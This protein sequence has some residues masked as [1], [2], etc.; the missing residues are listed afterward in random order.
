M[1]PL[2]KIKALILPP[3]LP[4]R[5]P[6]QHVPVP[7]PDPYLERRARTQQRRIEQ[8]ER[9]CVQLQQE[10]EE[11]RRRQAVPAAAPTPPARKTEQ[12][13]RAERDE[14]RKK[15]RRLFVA[16]H[17]LFRLRE[18]EYERQR[19]YAAAQHAD[20]M[21]LLREVSDSRDRL[22]EALT[23]VAG[24]QEAVRIDRGECPEAVL[25]ADTAENAVS[26]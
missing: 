4:E 15:N 1:N 17:R 20:D 23:W 16:A 13:L 22:F 11:A 12:R 19:Q 26:P 3:A 10:L 2:E 9:E 18:A 14:A 24:R 5:K 8:L 7:M 6:P 25:G 21:R